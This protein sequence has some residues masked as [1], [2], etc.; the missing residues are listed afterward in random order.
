MITGDDVVFLILLFIYFSIAA[1]F[2]A[3]ICFLY[4]QYQRRKN[5]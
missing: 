5:D 1:V 3:V 2:S 4:N